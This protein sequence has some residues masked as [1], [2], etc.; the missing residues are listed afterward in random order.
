MADNV[1]ITPGSGVNIATDEV[2]VNGGTTAHVQFV[3][4]VDGTSNGTTGIPGV[5]KGLHVVPHRDIVRI[6]TASSGLTT[7]TTSY[8][9]GDQMGAQFTITNAA[10]ASGGAGYVTGITLVSA[11]DQIGAVDVVLFD[12]SVTLAADNAAFAI[13]DAD[14][15]KTIAIVQLNGAYDIGNNRVAQAYNL[16]I[17]FVC[18]GTANL[19]AGLITRSTH[20]FFGAATDLQLIVYIEQS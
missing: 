8:A 4:L 11:A 14:A 20:T 5:A 1:E 17:P 2:Q 9:A 12:S 18:S 19:F 7:A 3:K 16:A 13:S 15:L 6:S 10:N